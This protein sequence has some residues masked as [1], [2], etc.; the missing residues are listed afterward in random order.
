MGI[1]E[2]KN[3]QPAAPSSQGRKT[4]NTTRKVVMSAFARNAMTLS[5][6]HEQKLKRHKDKKH[7]DS[8][9]CDHCQ[10]TFAEKNLIRHQKSH[11]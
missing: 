8:Y 2:I 1:A 4:S 11:V 6:D 3:V 9:K 10:K 5:N 7:K